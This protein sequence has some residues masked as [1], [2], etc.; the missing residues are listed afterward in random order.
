M[1]VGENS[2]AELGLGERVRVSERVEERQWK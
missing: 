1:E 2:G